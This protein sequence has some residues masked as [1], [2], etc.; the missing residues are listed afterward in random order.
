MILNLSL[1]PKETTSKQ[2]DPDKLLLVRLPSQYIKS[3]S[4]ERPSVSLTM[5]IVI[6]FIYSANTNQDK[7][8]KEMQRKWDI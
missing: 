6:I 7:R 2:S 1:F 3:A 8:I 5:V 4:P